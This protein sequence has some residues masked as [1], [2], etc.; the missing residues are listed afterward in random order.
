MAR[1]PPWH[2]EYGSPESNSEA[3]VHN[4]TYAANVEVRAVIYAWQNASTGL[5]D[6]QWVPFHNLYQGVPTVFVQGDYGG[7]DRL[8]KAA[9]DGVDVTVTLEA[10]VQAKRIART[11][12]TVIEGTDLK[13]ESM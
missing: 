4:P 1:S 3:L 8:S 7:L 12:W 10:N 9:D 11:L 13:N 2:I 5:V 6:G